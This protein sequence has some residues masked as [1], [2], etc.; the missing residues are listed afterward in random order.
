MKN[1]TEEKI[2]SIIKSKLA[3]TLGV[4]LDDIN[5]QAS[6]TE[7]LG[8]NPAEITDFIESLSTGGIE[9]SES[10]MGNIETVNDLIEIAVMEIDI[11]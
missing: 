7:H 1:N 6:L 5:N 10:D 2:R 11:E 9:I 4:E 3:S 8:M